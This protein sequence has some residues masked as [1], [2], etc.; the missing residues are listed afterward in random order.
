LAFNAACISRKASSG[1]D[2]RLRQPAL[3]TN[4]AANAAPRTRIMAEPSERRRPGADPASP[5]ADRRFF[6]PAGDAP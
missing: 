3:K 1:P 4:A 6:R 5:V 2:S